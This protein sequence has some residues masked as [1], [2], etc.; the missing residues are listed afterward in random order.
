MQEY[1]CGRTFTLFTIFICTVIG[2]VALGYLLIEAITEAVR[3]KSRKAVFYKLLL[4]LIF[5]MTISP[6]FF[7]GK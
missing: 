2:G 7:L 3:A 5:L 1:I 4:L 6:S